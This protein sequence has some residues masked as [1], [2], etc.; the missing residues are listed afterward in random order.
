MV[1]GAHPDDCEIKCG[2]TAIKL[3]RAGHTVRFVSAT[4]GEKGHHKQEGQALIDRRKQEACAAAE[5]AGV[6]SWV[7]DLPD[8]EIQPDLATRWRFIR[9]IR[10]FAPDVVIT[11]RPWDYHPDHRI[12]SQLVQDCSYLVRVPQVCPDVAIPEQAP[13]ILLM[14]DSFSQPLKFSADLA[15]AI[16]DVYEQKMQALHCHASQVYEWLPWIDGRE[17]VPDDEDGR[18]QFLKDWVSPRDSRV[19][20]ENRDC[21]VRL[22]GAEAAA[23]VKHAEAYEISEYGRQVSPD[24][25]A[26]QWNIFRS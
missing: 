14:A 2:G 12:T 13:V 16:D 25:L 5:V 1:I 22:Y 9:M 21:L 10:K 11:H 6:E 8:G 24:E 19:A 4:N 23:T 26:A 3:I 17:R 20:G 18:V 7:L 15:V